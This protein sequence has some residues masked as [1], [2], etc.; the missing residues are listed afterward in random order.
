MRARTAA[1]VA[2][3]G[4]LA[5]EAAWREPRRLVVRRPV[6]RLERWPAALDGLR[7]AV[8]ADLHAGAPHAGLRRVEEVV[9]RLN[10]ERPDV[11]ALLGDY[12]DPNV[13][14]AQRLAPEAVARRLGRLRARLGRVAVL[15]NHDW[16]GDGERMRRALQDAGLAVLEDDAVALGPGPGALWAVGLADLRYRRPDPRAAFD[17]VP[18]GA[19]VLALAHDPDLFPLLPD[20]AA[21]VLAGHTHGGQV[22]LPVVRGLVIPSWW[23]ERYAHGHVVEDGRHLYVSAGVGTSGLPVRLLAPPEIVVLELRAGPPLSAAPSA[24]PRPAG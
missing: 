4:L 12:V 18:A 1:A 11:V 14:F 21:L 2:A 22:S 5:L 17:G 15:G 20:R 23:G 24:A 13:L 6:L 9:A 16:H 19:A 7:V 8:V 10:A 3:A